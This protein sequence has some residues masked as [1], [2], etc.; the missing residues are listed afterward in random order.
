MKLGLDIHGVINANPQFYSALTKLAILEGHEVHILTGSILADNIIE[1]LKKYGV[2]WT[3]LFSIADYHTSLGTKMTFSDP[4]NPWIDDLLWDKTKAEYCVREKI[5]FHIDDTER[6]G[7]HFETLFALYDSENN[8]IDWNYK[9]EKHG[10]FTLMDPID[11]L[12]LIEK[13]CK[14]ITPIQ[15]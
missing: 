4:N 9:A 11:T 2:V 12:A 8:R 14:D 5:D 13:L 1:E 10:Q 7:E 15:I 3:K 6:Y